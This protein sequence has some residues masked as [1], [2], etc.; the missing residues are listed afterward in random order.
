MHSNAISDRTENY[1]IGKMNVAP[2][3]GIM[4]Q[5][6]LDFFAALTEIAINRYFDWVIALVERCKA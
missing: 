5:G 6:K 3:E 4:L 2:T 1:V